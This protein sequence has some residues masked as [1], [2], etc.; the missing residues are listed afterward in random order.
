M[1]HSQPPPPQ[2]PARPARSPQ[3]PAT[4]APAPAPQVAWLWP[5]A[6]ALPV[7]AACCAFAALLLDSR[8][9]LVWA[10]V[11]AAAFALVTVG[12]VAALR[13]AHQEAVR[14]MS[15][16]ESA[17]QQREAEFQHRLQQRNTQWSK[18]VAARSKALQEAIKHLVQARIPAVIAQDAVPAPYQSPGLDEDAAELLEDV[19]DA[20][21]GA[22]EEDRE[23]QESLRLALLALARR[24]QAAAHRIQEEAARMVQRHPTDA[25]ILQTSMRVD[26]AAAQQARQAQSLA[27]LCGEWPGQQWS[28]PLPLP[29]VVKGAAS[30][31]TAFHRVEVSGD[32]GVAVSAR[33]VEPLI[34]LVAELLSN[35]T[36]SSP[37]TT[38][39][40]WH[41]ARCS[42]A[43]SSRSTTA[44]SASTTS[45]SSRRA[46]SPPASASA[47]PSWARSR[48]P[49]S[50]SSGTTCA[51]TASWPT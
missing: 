6:L 16:R 45:S 28:E 21:G 15:R 51:A 31:I 43:Q 11:A 3:T 20:V 33:I 5:A 10:C 34:H 30:R 48:R 29:D 4:P 18:H 41:C 14:A 9:G 24:V 38:R 13:Q 1:A 19:L 44:A 22:A 47:S 37:P 7:V 8:S 39:C 25:D 26:H 17:M 12:A 36:Q 46:T 32:P 42:A 23:R 49:A 27:A 50:P 2:A 40:S 35:A